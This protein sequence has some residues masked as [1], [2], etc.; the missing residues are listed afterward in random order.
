MRVSNTRD[1][2]VFEIFFIYGNL[3][4][5]NDVVDKY[6]LQQIIQKF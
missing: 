6:T 3:H 5:F 1:A 2:M 4:D